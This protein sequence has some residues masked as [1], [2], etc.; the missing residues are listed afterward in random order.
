LEF[1]LRIEKNNNK[2]TDKQTKK[3]QESTIPPMKNRSKERACFK[4]LS[5]EGVR[6]KKR[7]TAMYK[8]SS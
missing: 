6:L 8:N 7:S 5:S 2:K 4:N 3:H 1:F